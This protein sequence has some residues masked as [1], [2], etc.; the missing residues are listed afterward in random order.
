MN[1]VPGAVFSAETEAQV[2]SWLQQRLDQPD[3]NNLLQL[4]ELGG[5]QLQLG[6]SYHVVVVTV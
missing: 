1:S 5:Y 3:E 4:L 2:V 6:H